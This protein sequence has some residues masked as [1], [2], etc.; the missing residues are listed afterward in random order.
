MA[1]LWRMPVDQL[2]ENPTQPTVVKWDSLGHI[3]LILATE[4][5]FGLKFN[6]AQIPKLT[7]LS[8]LCEEILRAR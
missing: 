1:R 3:R 4:K 7:S 2:P 6:T 8:A 5:E